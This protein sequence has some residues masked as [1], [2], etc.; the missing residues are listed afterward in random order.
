[1]N[2]NR[3]A[4]AAVNGGPSK[5]R[6]IV[7]FSVE[8]NLVLKQRDENRKKHLEKKKFDEKNAAIIKKNRDREAEEATKKPNTPRERVIQADYFVKKPAPKRAHEP[9]VRSVAVK[10]QKKEVSGKARNQDSLTKINNNPT[11]D[12]RPQSSSK[13]EVSK[14]KPLKTLSKNQ[15]REL[16]KEDKFDSLV[17]K[18]KQDIFGGRNDDKSLQTEAQRWF[19]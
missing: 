9:E 10:K 19:A 18:Y 8:N 4:F 16:Q 13:V 12:V 1:M 5:L 3:L 11:K 2:N 15:K 14:T 17:Q 7:E 6:P